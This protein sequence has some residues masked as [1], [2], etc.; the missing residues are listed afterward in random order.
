MEVMELDPLLPEEFLQWDYAGRQAWA[1]R[2][3]IMA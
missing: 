3:E 1:H 2:R